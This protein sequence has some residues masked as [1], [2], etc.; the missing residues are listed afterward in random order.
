MGFGLLPHPL[1]TNF[2]LGR[3]TCCAF[4]TQPSP[5]RLAD[6]ERQNDAYQARRISQYRDP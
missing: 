2:C 6:E 4:W 1:A 5:V 3:P